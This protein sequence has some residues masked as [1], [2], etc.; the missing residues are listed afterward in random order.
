MPIY[1]YECRGCG[2]RFSVLVLKSGSAVETRCPTC[3]GADLERL[4]SRFAM[5]QSEERRME[6]LADP[7]SFSGLDE[8]DPAS[9]ARWAKKMGREM[10]DG[11]G[12]GFD[13]MVDQA[14]GGETSREDG[15]AGDEDL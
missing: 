5:A 2:K 13:E 3:G 7:S 11:A 4:M 1:E 10:G 12:Q 9:V 6:K 14:V 15:S 8:N